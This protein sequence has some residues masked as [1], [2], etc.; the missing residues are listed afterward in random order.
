[1]DDVGEVKCINILNLSIPLTHPPSRIK[2]SDTSEFHCV[3]SIINKRFVISAAHC[4]CSEAIP[5]MKC[6]F[7]NAKKGKMKDGHYKWYG[8]TQVSKINYQPS[9]FVTVV[10]PGYNKDYRWV[11]SSMLAGE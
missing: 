7:N 11:S 2:G 4:Y 5:E 9:K 6:I 3:A 8:A 1:M 10:T